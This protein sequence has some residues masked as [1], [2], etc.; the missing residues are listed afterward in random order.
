MK[1]CV[2]TVLGVAMMAGSAV[3]AAQ[4]A[5]AKAPIVNA[6]TESDEVEARVDALLKA[7]SLDLKLD[8]I[9]GYKGFNIMPIEALKL[10]EMLMADGP[11]GVRNFGPTTAYPSPICLAATWNTD[12]ATGFGTAI[13]RDARARGVHIWLAPGVNLTRQPQCGRNFEY[14]GED[15][16]LTARMAV[17]VIKAV[18]AQGVVATV[19]HF[20]ANEQEADRHSVSSEVDERTLREIYLPPFAAAVKEAGVW[21]LMTSYNRINGVHASENDTLVNKLLKDEWKFRGVVMSDWESVYSTAGPVKAG[22]DLEMP[23]G[24]FMNREK[25]MPMLEDG[26]VT[27]KM[28]DDKVRRILRMAV[29][30]GFLDRSQRDGSIKLDD[31]A[32]GQAALRVAR[33]GIVLLKNKDGLLPL[34]VKTKKKILVLGP[35]ANPAVTGGGGS[36]FTTPFRSVSVVG[37]LRAIGTDFDIDAS[38]AGMG[39]EQEAL[40]WTG[41]EL[42][43]KDANIPGASGSIVGLKAEYFKG[44]AL[45]GEPVFTRF[46]PGVNQIWDERGPGSG[47]GAYDFSVRWTGLLRVP[48]TGEYALVSRS[49]DGIRVFVDGK[50]VSAMWQNQGATKQVVKLQLSADKPHDLKVEYFQAGGAAV[51]QFGVVSQIGLEEKLFPLEKITAAD[52]VIACVG[53]DQSSES[54]GFDRPFA[55]PVEQE[56]LL[57][58]LVAV[59]PNVVVVINAGASIDASAWNAKA[60]AMLMA[61]YPGQ[62]GNTA[63]AEIIFGKTNP[64]GKLP[65]TFDRVFNDLYATKD[66]P[67]AKDGVLHYAEGLMMGYRH[68]DSKKIAPLFPFGYG[69]SYTT[70]AYS[71]I[72]VNPS[73]DGTTVATVTAV[74]QN[75]GKVAGD[76]IAQLYVGYVKPTVTRPVHELKGFARVTLQPGEKKP[77]SF[78]ISREAL[79]YFDVSTRAWVTPAG[80]YQFFIGG[81]SRDLPMSAEFELKK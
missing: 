32:N 16:H 55:L 71:D 77:V 14:L 46:E 10:P 58:K 31:A 81:S 48:A 25:I 57:K 42:H 38:V 23:Y 45:A 79:A 43:A 76:E 3:T 22:L 24:K 18:Q 47:L 74:V 15:P 1:R 62:N 66:Y 78:S 11:A 56:T 9:G 19:K 80:S 68:Y 36:S 72:K 51:A 7:M 30:M 73:T 27:E 28:I 20:L 52:V 44:T 53:F 2:W 35:N 17:H 33:E 60:A 63:L 37:A 8:Y 41:Y 26:T 49:D 4:P 5:A 34:S 39:L 59:H 29:S 67:P 61:W 65:S 21:A 64:S 40:L 12:M 69:L 75:T 54:E 6:N 70:F 13:G 50:Q